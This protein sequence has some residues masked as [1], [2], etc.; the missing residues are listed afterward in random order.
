MTMVEVQM[1]DSS[2]Q[3]TSQHQHSVRR[4][5]RSSHNNGIVAVLLPLGSPQ[6]PP[7]PILHHVDATSTS[8]SDTWNNATISNSTTTTSTSTAS[9][10]TASAS[11]VSDSSSSSHHSLGFQINVWQYVGG[12]GFGLAAWLVY[13]ILPKGVRKAYC[14]SERRRYTRRYATTDWRDAPSDVGQP[15]TTIKGRPTAFDNP[16]S[17]QQQQQQLHAKPSHDYSVQDSILLAAEERRKQQG[18]GSSYDDDEDSSI[19]SARNHYADQHQEHYI[20][21]NHARMAPVALD[22]PPS[23]HITRSRSPD[24]DDIGNN[25][26][27]DSL[28]IRPLN[29]AANDAAVMAHQTPSPHKAR[30]NNSRY[31][32]LPPPRLDLTEASTTAGATAPSPW[33][34]QIRQVPEDRIWKESLR[35]LSQ[36]GVRLTAHGVQCD[37]KRIWLKY[38]EEDASLTWQTEFPRQVQNQSGSQSIVLMR[39]AMHRIP[40]ANVLYIDVGKKTSALQKT[41]AVVP[42]SACFSLLT[43]QGSLDLQTNSK[44]ERDAVVSSL[45]YLLDQVHVS[46][47]RKLYQDS[48]GSTAGSPSEMGSASAIST[49]LLGGNGHHFLSNAEI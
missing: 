5:K 22:R 25:D 44:L 2:P 26:E 36:R 34:P 41:S 9:S 6:P 7:I 40:L 10:S 15:P 16:H 45:C 31:Y 37:P 49:E 4:R 48:S 17:H 47:W 14:R 11:M 12:L 20:H 21:Y 28:H 39:G 3:S 32:D 13:L 24:L 19:P 8:D 43:Q 18:D 23:S 33:H 1:V 29:I 38:S 30:G 46:D 27:E 35:R 42:P